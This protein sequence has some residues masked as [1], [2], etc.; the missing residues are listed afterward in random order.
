MARNTKTAAVTPHSRINSQCSSFL[1][2]IFLCASCKFMT[3]SFSQIAF[4]S[5]ASGFVTVSPSS[6]LTGVSSVCDRAISIAESGTDSPCSHLDMVCRTTF[7]F[8]ASSS[9]ESPF[10]FLKVL[11]FSLNNSERL[12]SFAAGIL[13]KFLRCGKQRKV[14]SSK[15]DINRENPAAGKWLSVKCRAFECSKQFYDFTWILQ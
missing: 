10:A 15:G 9:C 13:S 6:V 8:T 2:R 3:S 14:T 12:L 11:I 4:R 7:S 5:S 1:L